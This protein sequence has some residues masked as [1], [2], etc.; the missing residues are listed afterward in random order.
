MVTQVPSSLSTFSPVQDEDGYWW[1]RL[2][3]E[4][5]GPYE[6]RLQAK[7]GYDQYLNTPP[8]TKNEGIWA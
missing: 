7:T 5:F 4:V 2:G 8:F 6:T 1:Y 3:M